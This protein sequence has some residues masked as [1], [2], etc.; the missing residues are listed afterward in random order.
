MMNL[1]GNADCSSNK[2]LVVAELAGIKV[3]LVETSVKKL[4]EPEFL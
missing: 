4:A 2:I 3:Q 1:L